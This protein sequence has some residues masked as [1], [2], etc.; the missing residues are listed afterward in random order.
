MQLNNTEQ[1]WLLTVSDR[2]KELSNTVALGELARVAHGA[3]ADK[4]EEHAECIDVDTAIILGGQE[5]G[6]HM[7][8]R[9]D[10]AARHHCCWLA[11]TKVGE[12]AAVIKV[13]L[14]I[15]TGDCYHH[16]CVSFNL[17]KKRH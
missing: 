6:C 11:E 13:Q 5:F 17:S 12:L 7:Q 4:P 15:I 14:P 1:V 8:R 9:A 3:R 16:C 2:L 10:H